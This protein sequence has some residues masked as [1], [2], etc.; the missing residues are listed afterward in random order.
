MQIIRKKVSTGSNGPA[1]SG[2]TAS[3]PAEPAS[4]VEPHIPR[5]SPVKPRISQVEPR[6]S[7]VKPRISQVEP[8]ISQVE[9]HISTVE[10]R[11]SPGKPHISTVEPHVPPEKPYI[12]Q[13]EARRIPPNPTFPE[14]SFDV[15]IEEYQGEITPRHSRRSSSQHSDLSNPFEVEIRMRAQS[16]QLDRTPYERGERTT[17]SQ[18]SDFP[19]FLPPDRPESPLT[20]DKSR[21]VS[22]MPG[23]LDVVSMEDRP[24]ITTQK[25]TW[26]SHTVYTFRVSAIHRGRTLRGALKRYA[27]LESL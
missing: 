6:T 12:P 18:P 14:P 23:E 26:G 24:E 21:L 9:P 10:P 5:I 11:T 16:P 27:G 1:S 19:R 4:P 2:S 3:P 25:D 8:R 13:V 22:I 17:R 15:D 7:P 20:T